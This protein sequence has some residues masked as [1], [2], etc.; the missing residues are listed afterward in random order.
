MSEPLHTQKEFAQFRGPTTSDNYNE[1]QENM[2]RDLVYLANKI[3]L[4]ERDV[5]W[6]HQREIKET[7]AL[8]RILED[9]EARVT[10]LEAAENKLT[11]KHTNQVDS[12]RFKGTEFEI[13][14]SSHCYHDSQHG[15]VTLPLV[16]GS[17]V[18][19]LVF[20]NSDGSSVLPS[21]FEAL[22]SGVTGT[23]D[24][25]AAT[26]DTSDPYYAVLA[27]PGKIWERNVIVD[28]PHTSDSE[29]YLYVKV[30]TDASVSKN[31]NCL[32]VHPYPILGC[33][34]IDVSYTVNTDVT[35]SE[36]DVYHTLN[37]SAI[38]S[39]NTDAVGW[40]PPGGWVGDTIVDCGPKVFYFDPLP[41]TG[42]RL[43]LKQSNFYQEGSKYLYS[44]GLSKLDARFNKFVDEG[45]VIFRFDAPG[46]DTI[47][48]VVNVTPD[49]WNV[50]EA[51]APYV[52]DYKIIWETSYD[53]G[54]YTNVPVPLSSRV[55][56]EVTLDKT[57]NKGTPALSGLTI[58]YT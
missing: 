32:V 9:L 35:L 4:A 12:D 15:V 55:W 3:G 43:R 54:V 17:S 48:S 50:S 26:I 16:S 13:A 44:Y 2:Y 41:I 24:G 25:G 8:T 51:E 39:G 30:P 5:A 38:H 53:S 28:T 19:K 18:S 37:S 31:T 34:L 7:F 46:S 10:T 40:L 56:I 11:F 58:D 42:F 57:I 22:A 52:F 45:K 47:S 21:S 36:S 6:N 23:A 1:R 14:D 49:I 27:E 33:E 20:I 29:V